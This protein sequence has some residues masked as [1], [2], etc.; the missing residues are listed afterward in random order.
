MLIQKHLHTATPFPVIP[1]FCLTSGLHTHPK[2]TLPLVLAHSQPVQPCQAVLRGVRLKTKKTKHLHIAIPLLVLP[3]LCLTTYT[4]QGNT[5]IHP[6]PFP[7][8]PTMPSDSTKCEV[9]NGR[10]HHSGSCPARPR[11]FLSKH[12]LGRLISVQKVEG[13][14]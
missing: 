1:R 2:T 10:I 8:C 3:R 14:E 9:K 12:S 5:A 7:A 11:L 6:S 13:E 4:S